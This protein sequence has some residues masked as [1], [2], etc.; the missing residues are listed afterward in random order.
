M[1]IRI[2]EMLYSRSAALRVGLRQS[3]TIPF[4]L[5]PAVETAGYYQTS[6]WRGTGV[7]RLGIASEFHD[8]KKHSRGRFC[9]CKPKSGSGDSHVE[10]RQPILKRLQSKAAE[11]ES[12]AVSA[13]AALR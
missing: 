13:E 2:L 5:F 4:L 10:Q 7:S 9:P 11:D 3:G 6:R 8:F 1:S 12:D